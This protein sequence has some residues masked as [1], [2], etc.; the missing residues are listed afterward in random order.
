MG[1]GAAVILH[2]SPR[3]CDPNHKLYMDNYFMTYNV[4]E[5]LAEKKINAA[6]TAQACRFA[7]PPLMDDKAM[8]KEE[9]GNYDQVTSIDGKIALVKWFDN[10]PV[11]LASY[12]VGVGDTDEVVRWDKKE[13]VYVT[14]NRPAVVK[15]YNESMGGVDLFDQLI[16]LYR[17][18]IRSRK[19]SLRM[20]THCFDLTVVNSWLEYQERRSTCWCSK[21]ECAG[22]PALQD[23]CGRVPC[24]NEEA[25]GPEKKRTAKHPNLT[26]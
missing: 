26:S 2:L 14:I 6:G 9:R 1:H 20:I 4:L 22:P 23:E 7:K 24:A 5:V 21:K 18:E 11:L 12:F 19:W 13:K 15:K 3:I 16:A 10:R 8:L 17:T 25:T